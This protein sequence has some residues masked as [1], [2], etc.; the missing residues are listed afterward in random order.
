LHGYFFDLDYDD[1][2]D[3]VYSNSIAMGGAPLDCKSIIIHHRWRI[4]D[5]GRFPAR[6]LSFARHSQRGAAKPTRQS[7]LKN[8]A[9]WNIC[10]AKASKRSL[11]L[12]DYSFLR[13]TPT[14][15]TVE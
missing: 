2:R 10:G 4:E 9:E 1:L 3:Y 7:N 14:V 13:P 12:I 6:Y 15:P 8:L 11:S 5:G